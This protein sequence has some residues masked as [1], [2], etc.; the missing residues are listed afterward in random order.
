M[1][2]ARKKDYT[3]QINQVGFYIAVLCAVLDIYHL[4]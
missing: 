4:V 1:S 3:E 2:V